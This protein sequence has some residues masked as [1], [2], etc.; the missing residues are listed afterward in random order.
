LTG[1]WRRGG[2]R[3]PDRQSPASA[4]FVTGAWRPWAWVRVHR[5]TSSFSCRHG[6]VW[7]WRQASE[8]SFGSRLS[9]CAGRRRWPRRLKPT[10]RDRRLASA[11][12]MPPTRLRPPGMPG[13]WTTLR[14]ATW[15]GS[16]CRHR[17][18]LTTHAQTQVPQ[19]QQARLARA[20]GKLFCGIGRGC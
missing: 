6:A 11:P 4:G 2:L 20:V 16:L 13:G 12:M 17:R 8:G 19:Q 10:R 1:G 14:C 5:R 15:E 7:L 18:H 3:H 9:R